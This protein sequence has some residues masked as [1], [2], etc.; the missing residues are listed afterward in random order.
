[1]RDDYT[2]R[3]KL[4][5][6]YWLPP[7]L[8]AAIVLSGSGDFL[9]AAHTG[10]FLSE[11]LARLTGHPMPE[12]Q[13]HSLHVAIRKTA[14]FTVYFIGGALFFRA[15]RGEE[16]GWRGRWAAGAVALATAVAVMDEWHQMFVPSRGGHA[17]DVL[18]D[19]AGAAVAQYVGRV[20]NPSTAAQ[21][22]PVGTG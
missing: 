1:M 11:L 8:W 12:Q 21:R 13:F 22:P 4:I 16:G 6:L 14:H 20:L 9:S 3:G 2:V 15:L 19:C 17:W 10:G 5:L 7:I 18:L